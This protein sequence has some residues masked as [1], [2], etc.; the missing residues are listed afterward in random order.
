MTSR[1]ADGPE[2][3]AKQKGQQLESNAEVVGRQIPVNARRYASPFRRLGQGL[4]PQ[5]A[6]GRASY[7]KADPF[8]AGKSLAMG[9][10][11]GVE[12]IS[13]G[14]SRRGGITSIWFPVAKVHAGAARMLVERRLTRTGDR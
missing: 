5:T 1:A 4:Q 9:Q 12:L 2:G 14:V 3:W 8:G 7:R 11:G 10:V 13:E 6:D